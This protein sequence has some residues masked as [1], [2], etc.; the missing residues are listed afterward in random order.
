M[1]E[2]DETHTAENDA[3]VR[4]ETQ[5]QFLRDGEWLPH[6]LIRRSE[7]GLVKFRHRVVT[8]TTHE[9]EWQQGRAPGGGCTC[10]RVPHAAGC[11]RERRTRVIPPGESTPDAS[12]AGA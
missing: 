9:G 2:P 11:L 5:T 4:V 6:V 10:G 3:R 8:I 7:I 12:E 1:S